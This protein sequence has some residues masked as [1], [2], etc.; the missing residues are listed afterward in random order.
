MKPTM[1]VQQGDRVKLGQVLFVDKKTPGVKYTAP[2][3]G[4][5]D[6]KSWR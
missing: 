1:Q 5:V 2:A 3:A 6:Y 4:G